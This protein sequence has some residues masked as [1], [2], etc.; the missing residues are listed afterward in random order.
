MT[1]RFSKRQQL[2]EQA[3]M[4]PDKIVSLSRREQGF[5]VSW[6]YRDEWLMRRCNQLVKEGRLRRERGGRGATVFLFRGGSAGL[7][8][9]TTEKGDGDGEAG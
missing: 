2:R 1:V 9:T 8:E 6:R 3:E 7:T 4:T 5:C